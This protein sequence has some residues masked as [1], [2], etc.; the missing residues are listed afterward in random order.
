MG[1]YK[2]SWA[3]ILAWILNNDYNEE[4]WDEGR[5]HTQTMKPFERDHVGDRCLMIT[6]EV[7]E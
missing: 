5:K 7:R 6:D 3:N 4:K 2:G 1:I